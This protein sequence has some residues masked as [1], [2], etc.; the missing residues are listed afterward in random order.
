M[1]AVSRLESI[2]TVMLDLDILMTARSSDDSP[3]CPR[4]GSTYNSKECLVVAGTF[5]ATC[6]TLRRFSFVAPVTSNNDGP[7][8]SYPCYM[9]SLSGKLQLEGF[10]LIDKDSWLDSVILWHNVI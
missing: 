7:H 2:E 9:R 8:R 1:N 3:T 4:L 5:M 6:P 10:D